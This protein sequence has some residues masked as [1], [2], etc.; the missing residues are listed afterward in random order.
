MTTTAHPGE[1]RR[2]ALSVLTAGL[3]GATILV[4]AAFAIEALDNDSDAPASDTAT[5]APTLQSNSPN[6]IY[7]G[8]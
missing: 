3:A 1:R 8:E 4:G 7:S 5:F 6:L 2:T